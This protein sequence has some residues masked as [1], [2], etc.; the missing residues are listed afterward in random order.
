[1]AEARSAWVMGSLTRFGGLIS[2]FYAIA[3]PPLGVGGLLRENWPNKG[4]RGAISPKVVLPRRVA[5]PADNLGPASGVDCQTI[6]TADATV[7]VFGVPWV[8]SRAKHCICD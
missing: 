7:G 1:L 2:N 5:L 8:A 6:V 3:N 4:T